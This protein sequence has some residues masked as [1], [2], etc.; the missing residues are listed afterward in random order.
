MISKAD[1]ADV[2]FARLDVRTTNALTRVVSE[3]VID[4][5]LASGTK[6][7]TTR[8][9]AD[10]A[11]MSKS[12]VGHAWKALTEQGIVE[13]RRR[14]G[15][16]V[17]GPPRP[18]RARRY[19]TMRTASAD[20]PIDL[21][22]LRGDTLPRPSLAPALEFAA[23]LEIPQPPFPEPIAEPLATTARELWPFEPESMLVTHGGPDGLSLYL[24][25]HV[26][27]GDRVLVES[28]TYPRTLDVIE[29]AGGIPVPIP[30]RENGP[31]LQ[32][33]HKACGVN[34]ALFVYQPNASQPFGASITE[35]WADA[36]ATILSRV[37][38]QVLENCL[39][40][41][42]DPH[43]ATLGTRLPGRVTRI[44]SYA[45]WFSTDVRCSLVGGPARPLDS[46]WS[47][48]TFSTRFVSR[49]LQRTLHHLLTDPATQAQ[50][51][52]CVEE[53]RRR[54]AA[55]RSALRQAGFALPERAGPSL[56]LPVPNEL[57][58]VRRAAE[59]GITI[60]P[61]NLCF[62]EPA[63]PGDPQF[64]HV[65]AT[66]LPDDYEAMAAALRDAALGH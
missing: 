58:A 24:Q 62:T 44:Q 61:G 36:A 22:N 41:L 57:D 17:V 30:W 40:S 53:A 60:F 48:L 39:S 7:P 43:E 19:A 33:L 9:F 12:T 55:F 29:R 45:L 52:V 31:D 11:G 34:P 26:Q 32:A 47:E 5:T 3:L 51:A 65:C 37:K 63:G 28:P 56:W 2:I 64:V 20:L 46:M 38:I 25:T 4:G 59:R 49:L 27:R 1:V 21:A 10:R 23:E 54:V 14:G 42:M 8:D 16:V 50:T 13:T 6:L 35:E 66:N 15:T 18:A